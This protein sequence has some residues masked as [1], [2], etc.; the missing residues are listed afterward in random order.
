VTIEVYGYA[1]AGDRVL[2]TTV[3]ET[4]LDLGKLRSSASS[5]RDDGL[6]VLTTFGVAPAASGLDLRFFVRASGET[7]SIRRPVTLP[8]FGDGETVLSQPI[9]MLAAAGRAIAPFE[10]RRKPPLEIPFRVRGERFFPDVAP[11]LKRGAS[12]DLCVF[13]WPVR[14]RAQGSF[15]VTGAIVPPGDE[16]LALRVE[17][18]RVV[19]DTDGFDRYVVTV[20]PPDAPPGRYGLRLEFHDPGTGRTSRTETT[21]R[22]E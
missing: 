19:P 18:G 1:V 22:I 15:E 9:A 17:K 5:F 7:G 6:H 2:D 10:S 14:D 4:T 16:P 13:A 8:D 11:V 21:V 3:V 20:V 12:R